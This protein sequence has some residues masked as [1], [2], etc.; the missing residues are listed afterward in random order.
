MEK[1]RKEWKSL[2]NS[3]LPSGLHSIFMPHGGLSF[4]LPQPSDSEATTDLVFYY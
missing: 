3:E 2:K 4:P 1:N